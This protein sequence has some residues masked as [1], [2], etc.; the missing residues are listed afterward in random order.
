[1][2]IKKAKHLEKS[3]CPVKDACDASL[4][5]NGLNKWQNKTR[6][7]LATNEETVKNETL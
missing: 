7:T 6:Y 3:A 2:Q 4:H 5:K 1:V